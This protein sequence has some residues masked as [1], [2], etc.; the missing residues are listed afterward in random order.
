MAA[1]NF[2]KN[3]AGYKN[4]N[5]ISYYDEQAI[6]NMLVNKKS[7][8]ITAFA[9]PFQAHA[10]VIDGY[11]KQKRIVT[12]K[13]IS[14]DSVVSTREQSREF[15]HCNFGWGNRPYYNGYYVSTILA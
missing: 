7:V 6:K 8:F 1:K 2:F 3:H 13:N 9:A 11:L 14:D 10:W 15:L 4:V 5:K 12:K